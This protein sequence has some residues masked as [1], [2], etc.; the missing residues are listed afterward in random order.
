M[1]WY[2]LSNP[3]ISSLIF[4]EGPLVGLGETCQVTVDICENTNAI[5]DN[6]IC[7]CEAGYIQ[8]Q[9]TCGKK[10]ICRQVRRMTFSSN[11]SVFAFV[12]V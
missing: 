6:G 10:N 8:E 4:F 3:H 9:D 5:C 2:T 7:E 12:F 1:V 11:E